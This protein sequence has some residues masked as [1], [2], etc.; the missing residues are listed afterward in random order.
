[1]LKKYHLVLLMFTLLLTLFSC[2]K[3]GEPVPSFDQSEMNSSG[4]FVIVKSGD[5]DYKVG[6]VIGGD[7]DEDDDGGVID[8][9]GDDID[10]GDVKG[11]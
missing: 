9:G 7:G 10:G 4:N 11:G 6:D 2:E 5:S 1:M 8:D 3:G